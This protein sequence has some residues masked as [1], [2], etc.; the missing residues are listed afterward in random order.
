M[1][2]HDRGAGEVVMK[3][4]SEDKFSAWLGL[5]IEEVGLGFCKLHFQIREDMLNGFQSVHGGILF[6]AA[7]SALAFAAATHGSISVAVEV[8]ISFTRPAKVGDLLTVE[9]R[10]LHKGNKIAVYDIRTYNQQSE[11]VT[12][13][14]GTVYRTGKPFLGE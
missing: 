10:E 6:S 5:G 14:K 8:A 2:F 7:D 13:F 3:M 1:I 12:V 11:L 9:A 4:Y